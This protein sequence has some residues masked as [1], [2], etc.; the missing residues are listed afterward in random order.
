LSVSWVWDCEYCGMR[1]SAQSEAAA[2]DAAARHA[3]WHVQQA[4]NE[5]LAEEMVVREE[6]EG[7]VCYVATPKGARVV[8]GD[9]PEP[10]TG[11]VCIRAKPT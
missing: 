11:E 3:K 6:R 10:E 8:R 4:L 1:F 7:R 2:S 9:A 5:L